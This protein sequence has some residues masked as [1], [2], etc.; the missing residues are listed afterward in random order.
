MARIVG[1]SDVREHEVTHPTGGGVADI[2]GGGV[3]AHPATE[4]AETPIDA[5]PGSR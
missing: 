2:D 1:A 3:S 4:G 5:V